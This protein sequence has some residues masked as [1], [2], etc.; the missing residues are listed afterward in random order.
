[1]LNS[2]EGSQHMLPLRNKNNYLLIIFDS[3]L[4]WSS[5][6][7]CVDEK[8]TKVTGISHIGPNEVI[9]KREGF[10]L[11]ENCFLSRVTPS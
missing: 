6:L 5:G 2:N 9:P 11:R 1:M 10:G 8:S 7:K 4:I 3:T